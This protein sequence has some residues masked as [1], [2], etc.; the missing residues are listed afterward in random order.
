[1]NRSAFLRDAAR[2][3][4]DNKHEVTEGGIYVPGARVFIGGAFSGRY[5]EPGADFGPRQLAG[6]NRV[7]AQGLNHILN[8]LAGHT[9]NVPLYLAPFSGNV[10]PADGWTGATWAAAATEFTAYAPA[11]RVPWTTVASTAKELSN[12]AALAD[13]TITFSAGGPYTIRGC[14]LVEASAKSAT[15]GIAVAGSRFDADL[16]GMVGGG[17]L[18]LQYDLVAIDEGDA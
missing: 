17:R 4:R 15:T 12:T 10:T 2:A 1:M 6:P 8:L 16:T 13:A 18:A 3:V 9:S 14:T 5:A 11:S 7:F